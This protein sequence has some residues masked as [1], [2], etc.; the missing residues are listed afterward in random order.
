VRGAPPPRLRAPAG[1]QTLRNGVDPEGWMFKAHRRHGDV[2]AI[3]IAG[4]SAPFVVLAHPDAVKEAFAL[5]PGSVD[6]GESADL[7]KPVI[8]TK[9]LLML[10]GQE[11]LARRKLV[12]PPF[13]GDRLRTYEE[14]IRTAARGAA[15]E[16]PRD[17]PAPVLARIQELTFGVI[18]RCVF[19]FEDLER[20]RSLSDRLRELLTWASDSRR[21]VLLFALG[22][23]RLMKLPRFRRLTEAVDAE[24][25]A[26]IERR[27]SAD[28]L[29][30]RGDILSLL[31]QA[32]GEDGQPLTDAELRDE[33]ITLLVVGHE[34]GASL[35]AWSLHELARATETQERLAAGDD[36]YARAVVTETL[37]LRPP[38]P[39]VARRL[40]EPARVAGYDLPAGTN[41]MPCQLLVHRRPDLYEAPWSFRPERFVDRQPVPSEWFPF[42]GS[43]R[44]C[45]GASFAQLEARLVL[46]ELTK[47]M[48][49]TATTDR[50]ERAKRRSVILIPGGGARLVAEARRQAV[51]QQALTV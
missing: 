41:L 8:G 5:D 3:R 47:G 40:L 44:R 21:Q 4:Q 23:D 31:I 1:W 48:R 2:F 37:R 10:A 11:H 28:D 6:N 30:E 19:G 43:V 34:T 26:E 14:V 17:R 42:G 20:V 16:W 25:T 12:L 35:I 18:L 13:H 29:A 24:L 51:P 15:G 49:F 39:V 38:S 36:E 32:R 33:L 46:Q 9:N 45:V 50:P 27:R 7:L 22:A